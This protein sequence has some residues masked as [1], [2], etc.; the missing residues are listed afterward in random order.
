MNCQGYNKK[1]TNNSIKEKTQF[2]WLAYKNLERL[3]KRKEM[4]L[5]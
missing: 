5:D 3:L 4:K 2:P 1:K